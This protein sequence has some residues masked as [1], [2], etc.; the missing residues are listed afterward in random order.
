MLNNHFKSVY[1]YLL[2]YLLYLYNG[3][4]HSVFLN[5]GDQYNCSVENPRLSQLR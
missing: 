1:P 2:V 4:I 3:N 5:L